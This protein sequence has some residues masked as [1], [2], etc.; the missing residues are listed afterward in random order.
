M[1]PVKKKTWKIVGLLGFLKKKFLTA[2]FDRKKHSKWQF[3][4]EVL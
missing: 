3:Y 2:T 4:F 1:I